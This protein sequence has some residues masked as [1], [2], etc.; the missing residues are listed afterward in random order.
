[1]TPKRVT[2]YATTRR[3]CSRDFADIY[4]CCFKIIPD[5]LLASKRTS[6]RRP[7]G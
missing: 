3:C 6:T 4:V 5:K 2:T 7:Y 1:M